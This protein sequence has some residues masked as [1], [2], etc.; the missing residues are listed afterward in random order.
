MVTGL[1]DIYKKL[2]LK[3]LQLQTQDAAL[4]PVQPPTV[5]P[6]NL[7]EAMAAAEN[8]DAGFTLAPTVPTQDLT[9]DDLN[10]AYRMAT[11][12]PQQFA[13]D[14][15]QVGLND[16]T[17]ALLKGLGVQDPDIDAFFA[18][19]PIAP[20]PV[21]KQPGFVGTGEGY[22][23]PTKQ[24]QGNWF[25]QNFPIASMVVGSAMT[26]FGWGSEKFN[27]A[28]NTGIAK[29]P[30]GQEFLDQLT[31]SRV[32][33]PD[34]L[35]RSNVNKF[36]LAGKPEL[37]AGDIGNIALSFAPIGGPAGKVP[38]IARLTLKQA[39]KTGVKAAEQ[40]LKVGAKKVGTEATEVAAKSAVDDLIKQRDDLLGA[41]Q[42]GDQVEAAGKAAENQAQIDRLS[43][44][45]AEAGKVVP[46]GAPPVEPP[47]PTG[48]ENIKQALF[49]EPPKEPP[50]EPP[51]GTTGAIP[52]AE[53]P[54]PLPFKEVSIS[55]V[56]EL[57]SRIAGQK[58]GGKAGKLLQIPVVKQAGKL[59][60]PIAISDE[61]GTVLSAMSGMIDDQI[62]G[63]TTLAMSKPVREMGAAGKLPRNMM[64]MFR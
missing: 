31:K 15:R 14:L 3:H 8:Q 45:I 19:Q 1:Q 52:P 38:K 41:M 27:E 63:G 22:I 54:K 57:T 43:Q 55:T 12:N 37:S 32:T 61:P 42:K 25:T 48:L 2:K 58:I 5:K 7:P 36:L 34:F 56:D 13:A 44:Q 40:A 50:I 28:V 62:A 39:E 20:E 18:P 24:P 26:A 64:N 23:P 46:E 60:S 17:R 11:N 30:G 21:V 6:I 16:K 10:F 9:D 53:A 4:P 59:V 35:A 33:L 47:K 49:G 29:L 51:K